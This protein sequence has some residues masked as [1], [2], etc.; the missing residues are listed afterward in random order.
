MPS[1]EIS[2]APTPSGSARTAEVRSMPMADNRVSGCRISQSPSRR[3]GAPGRIL[4][5]PVAPVT[6]AFLLFSLRSAVR[7]ALPLSSEWYALQM[8]RFADHLQHR[9]NATNFLREHPGRP[10]CDYCLRKG[11]FVMRGS[12]T[13]KDATLV[14][15]APGFIREMALCCM[16]GSERRTNRRI[17]E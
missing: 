12:L 6:R 15:A 1:E 10:Y 11:L 4:P 14:G 8:A 2:P 3:R 7:S 5:P 17:V 9:V 13:E 16:C